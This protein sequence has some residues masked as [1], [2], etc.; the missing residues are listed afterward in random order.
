MVLVLGWLFSNRFWRNWL[1]GGWLFDKGG[2]VAVGWYPIAIWLPV[3]L[4]VLSGCFLQARELWLYVLQESQK[5][6]SV[7]LNLKCPRS[8]HLKHIGLLLLSVP[9]T[10]VVLCVP[11]I[12]PALLLCRHVVLQ[13]IGL[14]VLVV[15]CSVCSG[16]AVCIME[17]FSG[18]S[19]RS[20]LSDVVA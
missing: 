4:G 13:F 12:V 11:T 14:A 8:P 20:L 3:G 1:F 2:G 6:L 10:L 5:T 15:G 17:S 7:Q 18:G 9:V 19:Y 16:D